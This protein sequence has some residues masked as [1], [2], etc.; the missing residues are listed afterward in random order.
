MGEDRFQRDD[1]MGASE[2]VELFREPRTREMK[3]PVADR[4]R[5][6]GN[7]VMVGENE[8]STSH[9]PLTETQHERLGQ[10]GLRNGLYTAPGRQSDH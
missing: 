9:Q 3:R 2:P 10:H 5:I 4:V 6:V 1:L 7:D 8:R